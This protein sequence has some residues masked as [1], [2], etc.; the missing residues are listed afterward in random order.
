MKNHR[1]L[2]ILAIAVTVLI[3]LGAVTMA[4]LQAQ[5]DKLTEAQIN[6]PKLS[7]LSDGTYKGSYT[8][9]PV[10]VTVEVTV[11]DHQITAI[12]ILKHDN[13]K[14]KPAEVIVDEVIEKQSL[15]V[16]VISGATYSSK[17][18]LK[19]IENALK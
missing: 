15:D 7:S 14:G 8:A 4:F 16:D 6:E 19:A 11:S 3:I 2:K 1:W 18:I 13:G 10:S 12:K 9:F 17:V 5:L